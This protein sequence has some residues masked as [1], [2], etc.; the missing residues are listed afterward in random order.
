MCPDRS[1]GAGVVTIYVPASDSRL[2]QEIWDGS[3]IVGSPHE[4]TGRV[5]VDFEGNDSRYP[6]YASRVR[7]AA[8]RHLWSGEHRS[9]YP[10]RACAFCSD[11][12]LIAVG[13]Y[14]LEDD[15]I[16][17]EDREALDEWLDEEGHSSDQGAAGEASNS[18]S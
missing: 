15:A 13:R 9:G 16:A 11:G 17:I 7:R 12:D 3:G 4:D 18:S 10:T 14:D 6:S 2:R 5:R 1:G 8:E